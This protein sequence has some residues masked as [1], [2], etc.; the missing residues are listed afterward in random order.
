ML[1]P[2]LEQL[3]HVEA[4]TCDSDQVG[5]KIRQFDITDVPDASSMQVLGA[6]ASDKVSVTVSIQSGLADQ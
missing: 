6:N 4:V 3:K 5:H 2:L 1:R